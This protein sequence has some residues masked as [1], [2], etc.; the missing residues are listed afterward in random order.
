MWSDS[1][2]RDK[3]MAKCGHCQFSIRNEEIFSQHTLFSTVNERRT[4]FTIFFYQ[5]LESFDINI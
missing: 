3:N 1:I 5:A 2:Q 4:K